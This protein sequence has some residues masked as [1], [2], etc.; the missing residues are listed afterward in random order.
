MNTALS[1]ATGVEQMSIDQMT[2][3]YLVMSFEERYEMAVQ[4]LAEQG[5]DGLKTIKKV[6][7]RSQTRFGGR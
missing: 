4:L 7:M 6:A 2:D 5:M 1:D 3:L